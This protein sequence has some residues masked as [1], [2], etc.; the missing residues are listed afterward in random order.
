[1]IEKYSKVD[2]AA[3][4]EFVTSHENGSFLQSSFW[5]SVKKEWKN[6]IIVS[7]DENGKINGTLSLLIRRMPV[8]LFNVT[9]AY[10]PRGPVCDYT[11]T[12]TMRALI[13]EAKAVSKS[14]GACVVKC[15]PDKSYENAELISAAKAL[16]LKIKVH[17]LAYENMQ[18]ICNHKI[19]LSK[20]NHPLDLQFFCSKTRN[21]IRTANKRGAELYY[22]TKDDIDEFYEIIKETEARNGISL[23]NAEYYRRMLDVIPKEN[24]LFILV[25][26]EGR[27]IAGGIFILYGKTITYSYSAM[28]N[29]VGK[30]NAMY[31]IQYEIMRYGVENG[32]DIYDMGGVDG[33]DLTEGI[34]VFKANFGGGVIRNIGE[35]DAVI[36]PFEYF[37]FNFSLGTGRKILKALRRKK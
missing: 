33:N 29:G 35:L 17:G 26:A 5:P 13:S 36:K 30:Y 31:L 15:D 16:G 28:A 27:V 34:A 10:A 32:Y 4:E 7:K 22:G 9:V 25:K 19:D 1:M 14:Y 3:Y 11:D 6:E 23:R 20:A 24:L 8:P 12:E 21:L 18:P 37:L 2:K